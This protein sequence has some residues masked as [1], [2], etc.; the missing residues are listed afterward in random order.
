MKNDLPMNQTRAPRA[1]P[2]RRIV[3]IAVVLAIV[4]AAGIFFALRGGA[5]KV[6]AKPAQPAV[7]AMELAPGDLLRVQ[8]RD[9]RVQ[10]PVSGALTALNQATVKSK[11]AGEVRETPVPE[12]VKVRRGD[13]VVRLDTADLKARL[14]GQQATLE[15]ARA[16]LTLANKNHENNTALLKQKFISQNALDTA[17]SNV[18]LAQA[19]V[20]AAEAQLDIARRALDDAIVRA[21]IDGI[22]SKRFVQIGEKAAPDMAL[23]AIVDL[24]QL[25]LEAQVPAS[26]IP[27]ISAGQTVNFAVDGFGARNFSGKVVRINPAAEAGSRA[28][29][30]YVA[31]SNP[32][33]A[34]K[35]GMFA[36]G[37]IT[38]EKSAMVP[39][40][41]L[42]ALREK[43]G[44]VSV[45]K[46][47]NGKVV[48]QPVRLGLRNEDEGMVEV[49]SGIAVGTLVLAVKLDGV[50]AGTA[51]RLPAKV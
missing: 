14:A 41:P 8:A 1:R 29:I 5:A 39:A 26:E 48:E 50:K 7:A 6:E 43:N 11:V 45:L 47:D 9:L 44:V 3:A 21:P 38:L 28:I 15:D 17:Q 2:L 33:S 25:I 51:V 34:L 30:V 37:G 42:S 22:I 27:R 23:F 32:D 24:A 4:I 46:I 20:K 35:S 16:R 13:I 31:V 12:G 18:E 36:K 49:T 40:V 19:A 10:L